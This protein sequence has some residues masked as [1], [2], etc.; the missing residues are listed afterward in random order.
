MDSTLEPAGRRSG[1]DD[2][3]LRRNA[4]HTSKSIRNRDAAVPPRRGGESTSRIPPLRLSQRSHPAPHRGRRRAKPPAVVAPGGDRKENSCEPSELK[5]SAC[6]ESTAD[7]P[8]STRRKSATVI[9]PLL[10]G[11]ASFATTETG[12]TPLPPSLYRSM[13]STRDGG[14]S[15]PPSGAGTRKTKILSRV[16]FRNPFPS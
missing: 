6:G 13:S 7:T 9:V 3:L 11:Y 1:R 12:G 14:T 5:A 15:T 8:P 10:K 2:N 16:L 4:C